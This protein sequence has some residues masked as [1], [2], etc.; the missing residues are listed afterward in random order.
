MVNAES[1]GFRITS[2]II[3]TLIAAFILATL[4]YFNQ[5]KGCANCCLT[6]NEINTMMVIGAILFIAVLIFWIWILIR[7]FFTR[8]SKAHV[9]NAKY[10]AATAPPPPTTNGYTY[11]QTTTAYTGPP[12]PPSMAAS[13][14]PAVGPGAAGPPI[15][16]APTM[17]DPYAP[18]AMAPPNPSPNPPAVPYGW[19]IADN[20]SSIPVSTTLNLANAD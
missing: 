20:G 5:I 10:V 2:F 13:P 9:A 18:P 1:L 7:L 15:Y 19:S 17:A 14:R 12:P 8:K 6:N 16:G 11:G 4:I 3:V